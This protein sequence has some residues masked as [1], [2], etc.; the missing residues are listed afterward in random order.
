[1]GY[2]AQEANDTIKKGGLDAVAFGHH[3]VSNPDLVERLRDG[4]ILVEPDQN[5]YYSQGAKDYTDYPTK[6]IHNYFIG[7]LAV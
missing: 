7:L 4:S 2:T 5:T 1:M 3:Y 6:W